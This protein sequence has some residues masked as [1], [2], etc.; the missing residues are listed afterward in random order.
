MS[1][2]NELTNLVPKVIHYCW[3]SD[4]EKPNSIK[5]CMQS[6]KDIMPDYEIVCWDMNRFPVDEYLFVKAACEARK[7]AFAA[8]L[9]RLY[10]L[11]HHGGIYLDSDVMVYKPFDI[12]LKHS[13][14]SSIELHPTTFFRGVK[15]GNPRSGLGIEAAVMG[16]VP[17]HPWIKT[18]LDHYTGLRFVNEPKFMYNNVMGGT[19]AHLAIPLG[20]KYLP[21]Y[22]QLEQ[23]IHIYPPDVF[24]LINETSLVKYSTHKCA[25]SWNPYTIEKTE[26]FKRFVIEKVIGKENWSKIRKRKD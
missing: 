8:D 7:W 16:A 26:R 15:K 9:I 19:M 10:A 14:F 11:Y 2:L 21:I 24:S 12:F 4:D 13:V 6:W 1:N 3:L 17:K 22:Q 25:N 18:C 5:E 20:F 23:D